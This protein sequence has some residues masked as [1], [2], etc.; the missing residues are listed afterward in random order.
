[1]FSAVLSCLSPSLCDPVDDSSPG[2]SVQ[3]IL[4]ARILEWVAMPSS[5]GFSQSLQGLNPHLPA[6]GMKG[7][8]LPQAG[9]CMLFR[10]LE[11]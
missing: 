3:G 5:G 2:S 4:W 7:T 1:M 8:Q 11:R 6:A 10:E 9:L